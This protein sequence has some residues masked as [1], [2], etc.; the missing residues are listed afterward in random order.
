M[1][2]IFFSLCFYQSISLVHGGKYY[3]S[4]K[5]LNETILGPGRIIV[6]NFIEPH[7]LNILEQF[8]RKHKDKLFKHEDNAVKINNLDDFLL[9]LFPNKTPPL[10]YILTDSDNCVPVADQL[11]KAMKSKTDYRLPTDLTRSN[12]TSHE[13]LTAVETWVHIRNKMY[14]FASEVFNTTATCSE[15]NHGVFYY[16]PPNTY[17]EANING[18]NYLYPPHYDLSPFQGIYDRPLRMRKVSTTMYRQ[19]TAVLYFTDV[20]PGHGGNF[21]YMDLLNHDHLPPSKGHIIPV[22]NAGKTLVMKGGIFYNETVKITRVWPKRGRL[23]LLNAKDLHAVTS[24]TGNFERWGYCLFMTDAVGFHQRSRGI[25]ADWF[26]ESPS[27]RATRPPIT[28]VHT[29]ST[30]SPQINIDI[31]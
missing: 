5:D 31:T 20:P 18:V 2:V 29:S 17:P 27:F 9:P 6:D 10:C 8:L 16:F 19:F 23:V 25:V 28:H 11:I 14:E 12:F 13:L 7:H 22:S 26:K 1:W 30:T 24:F 15:D 3:K 4:R 21:Q